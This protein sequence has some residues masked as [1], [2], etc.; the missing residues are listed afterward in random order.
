MERHLKALL[1]IFRQMAEEPGILFGNKAVDDPTQD[2]LP[3][4]LFARRQRCVG[5]YLS[6]GM[7]KVYI[8]FLIRS[9]APFSS[10]DTWAWEMP[11]SL[12][13]SICVLPL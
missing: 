8:S 5:K 13:I 10:L 1:H 7:G 6:T 12:A 2:P 9:K 3:M 11:I 4:D